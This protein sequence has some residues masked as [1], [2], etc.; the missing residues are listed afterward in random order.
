[1][2]E[3]EP[4]AEDPKAKKAAPPAKGKGA[5]AA[6]A[7]PATPPPDALGWENLSELL[8]ELKSRSRAYDEW[9]ASVKVCKA[10]TSVAT[11]SPADPPASPREDSDTV[12]PSEGERA[13]VL[14]SDSMSY[15]ESILEGVDP[16]RQNVPVLMHAIL[17][18]VSWW[19]AVYVCI[20]VSTK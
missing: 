8:S 6:P 20:T 3:A 9:R 5:E 2:S 1:M 19:R 7:P 12:A 17:E 10:Q 16:E 13:A 15:Y 14:P 11:G 18:Q 4:V